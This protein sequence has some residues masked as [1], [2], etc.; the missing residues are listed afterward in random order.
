MSRNKKC[1]Y[2][3]VCQAECSDSCI[4]YIEMKYLMDSSGIP[5]VQQYP[6]TIYI[7][8]EDE[9]VYKKLT[10]IKKNIKKWVN[11]GTHDIFICSEHAGNAKTTWAIKLLLKYF[12]EIWSGNGLQVRGM[13]VHVPT[14]LQQLKNFDSDT[15]LSQEYIENLK[16]CDVVV[17]DDIATSSHLTDYEY[18]QLLVLIDNR[19]FNK[20]RNIYTSNIVEKDKLIEAIGARLTSR[21]YDNSKEYVFKSNDGRGKFTSKN[22]DNI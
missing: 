4:R 22:K 10:T 21:I 5:P 18:N 7:T 3:N 12:D 19:V 2:K 14:L 15:R 17:W 16:T 9:E 11:T 8:P 6:G 20:K 1:W 13:F